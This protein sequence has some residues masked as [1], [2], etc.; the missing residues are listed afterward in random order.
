MFNYTDFHDVFPTGVHHPYDRKLQHDIEAHRKNVEGLL[1]IDRVLRALGISKAKAYPPK[2]E[3][4]LRQ[5][6]QQICDAGMSMHHKFSLLYYILLDFDDANKDAFVSGSF[7]SL[8]GMPA[9]YQLFMKGLWHMDREEFT[10]AVEYVAHP[11]LEPDFADDIIIT[12]IKRAPDQDFSLALSYFYSVQPIL[13]TPVALELLFDAMARTNV[14]Q[15]LLYSRTHP[16]HTREQLFRRWISRV[17]DNGR[18]EDLSSR[19]SELAFMPFDNLEETWFEEYL[20]V[21]EGR[22]LKK[23]KDTLLIRKIACDRFSD[24]AR[25]RP[26][27]QWASVLEGIKGGTEGQTD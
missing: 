8:S 12:L 21:G 24:V 22:N 2:T 5:L 19:T 1:F 27:G 11:S 17:L 18:R 7:A 10:R 20:T 25:I 4:A 16:Q 9:N 15:A 14:T 23:A 3:N 26:S 13:K 6:H